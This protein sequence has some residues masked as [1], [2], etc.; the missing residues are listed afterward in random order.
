MKKTTTLVVFGESSPLGAALKRVNLPDSCIA[1]VTK[2]A[3][4][5][6]FLPGQV[7][8]T[9]LGT[10][11]LY[12]DHEDALPQPF[13]SSFACLVCIC[14][15]AKLAQRPAGSLAELQRRAP[16][17]SMFCM[18]YDAEEAAEFVLTLVA[19]L[20]DPKVRE[21]AQQMSNNNKEETMDFTAKAFEVCE[22]TFP[23][24][25]PETRALLE[26][27]GSIRELCG[28][29]CGTPNLRDFEQQL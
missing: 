18:A 3:T 9:S 20:S 16:M 10:S 12:L 14:N 28:M 1:I 4:S 27:V 19:K 6:H 11:F 26:S 25:Q 17:N 5:N 8:A 13:H 21:Q 7:I 15:V 29:R 2:P 23:I 22:A 24:P